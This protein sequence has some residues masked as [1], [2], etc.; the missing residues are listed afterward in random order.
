MSSILGSE[1]KKMR[2]KSNLTQKEVAEKVHV[3][4]ETISHWENNH[5]V[6]NIFQFIRLSDA[7]ELKLSES[8]INK[9]RIKE[10]LT[11]NARNNR[12]A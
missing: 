2:K 3:T 8:Y 12:V 6:P 1:I 4:A 10:R 7:C 9:L 11:Q 5:S